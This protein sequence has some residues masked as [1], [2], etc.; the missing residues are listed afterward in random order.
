MGAGQVAWEFSSQLLLKYFLNDMRVRS[1][2]PDH[3]F[4]FFLILDSFGF[5]L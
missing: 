1:L 2:K 5:I 3:I 4:T